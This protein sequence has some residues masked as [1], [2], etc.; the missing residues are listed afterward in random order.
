VREPVIKQGRQVLGA[1]HMPTVQGQLKGVFAWML[2]NTFGRLP[3]FLVLLD[4]DFWCGEGDR[5]EDDRVREIL[6]YHEMCHMVHKV[7]LDGE[8]RFSESGKPVFGLQAHDVE[9]FANTVKRYGA[10]SAEIEEFIEAAKAG[11]MHE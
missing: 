8:P 9:E 5:P 10:Y 6:M 11:G 1:V 2:L 4:K 3:D 7:D